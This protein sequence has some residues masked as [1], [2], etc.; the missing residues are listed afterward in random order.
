MDEK[1]FTLQHIVNVMILLVVIFSY[2]DTVGTAEAYTWHFLSEFA[3]HCLINFF[4][5]FMA[6]GVFNAILGR[7]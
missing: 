7:D 4:I 1:K 2:L 5:A 6:L 3:Y